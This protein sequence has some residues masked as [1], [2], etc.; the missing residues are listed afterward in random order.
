LGAFSPDKPAANAIIEFL[1][2]MPEVF[3]LTDLNVGQKVEYPGYK[4][5][6]KSNYELSLSP[7]FEKLWD[8]YTP[9]CRK[10]ISTASKK[11]YVISGNVSP[12]ELMSIYPGNL[13]FSLRGVKS[14]DYDRL[15][16]LIRYCLSNGKGSILGVRTP[17]KKLVYGIFMIKIPGSITIVLESNTARSVEKHIG[18]L[19]INEIIKENSTIASRLD[20]AG[21]WDRS[22]VPVGKSFGGKNIPYYRIFRNRL[23]LPARLLK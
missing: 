16:D 8:S 2:Y 17:R 5:T 7:H 18:F 4:V 19:V 10:Y 21:T 14:N 20:F 11:G 22:A 15:L 23:L 9:E 6:E 12:E 1:D 13:G 3:R